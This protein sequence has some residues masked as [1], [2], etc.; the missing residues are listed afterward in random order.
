M[1][2]IITAV[3]A[4][5]IVA[6]CATGPAPIPVPVAGSKADATVTLAANT[7]PTRHESANWAGAKAEAAKRC[8]VWGYEDADALG[9]GFE[10]CVQY[11]TGIFQGTCVMTRETATF[12]CIG[13]TK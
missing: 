2:P 6:G 7:N 9:S 4:A 13:E 5:L 10:K 3:S 12:Q 1:I 11:G 8:Q